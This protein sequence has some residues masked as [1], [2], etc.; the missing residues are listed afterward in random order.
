MYKEMIKYRVTLAVSGTDTYEITSDLPRDKFLEW[1]I[2][3]S[4]RIPKDHNSVE[5]HTSIEVLRLEV[6]DQRMEAY[7]KL[8]KYI[9]E[10]TS[11]SEPL[12]L[13][14][15]LKPKQGE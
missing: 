13:L 12:E 10:I 14:K 7:S 6:V 5:D 2:Q 1:A 15:K 8:H 4:E 3:H 9:A 11:N